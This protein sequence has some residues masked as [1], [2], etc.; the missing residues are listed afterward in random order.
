MLVTGWGFDVDRPQS[1]GTRF[2]PTA[3]WLSAELQRGNRRLTAEPHKG[4]HNR[5]AKGLLSRV[6]CVHLWVYKQ[7]PLRYHAFSESVK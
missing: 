3:E 1:S 2:E 6:P 5:R 4:A 7:N